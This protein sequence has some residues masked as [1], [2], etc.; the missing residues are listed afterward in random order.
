MNSRLRFIDVFR[1]L[2]ILLML[3]GHTADA[4][5]TPNEKATLAFQIYTVF[6]GFTAPMFLFIS[7]FAFSFT[8]LKYIDEYS[9]FSS[10]F[11]R[12]IRKF[13]FI[14]LLGYF[15]H[16]PYLSLRKLI[17]ETSF[18][19]LAL[20]FS[21]DVLQVIGISL[22][23]LQLIL[24]VKK[25]SEKF[26]KTSLFAGIF[27]FLI[28]P[29]LF[30]IDFSNFLPL[31]LSQYLNSFHGSK[32]PLFPWMGYVMIGAYM[33][34]RFIVNSKLGKTKDFFA[35]I[36]K[37]SIPAFLASFV[38]E[39]V[40]EVI[41]NSNQFLIYSS[42]F[43]ALSRLSFVFMIFYLVWKIEQRINLKFH[44]LQTLGTESLFAYVVHLMIIYGSPLNPTA[45]LSTLWRETLNYH[46]VFVTFLTI[47]IT[48]VLLSY[49]LNNMRSKNDRIFRYLKY[50][51][52]N[53]ILLAF[54]INPY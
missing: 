24:F 52:A 13:F 44:P 47:T 36:L 28:S 4:L 8:T 34:H 42:P 12:R 22:L 49:L 37:F 3:H 18:E 5:L 50:A 46:L 15:L 1:G 16:L 33:G 35:K 31:F 6:R 7:G 40:Y 2:A 17:N 41:A 29:F 14:T 10:K 43:L 51:V 53:G 39:F 20:L 9:Q 30:M 54:L 38:L 23:T 48:I 26:S 11:L 25:D 32:F 21:S 19:T 45:S 27:S